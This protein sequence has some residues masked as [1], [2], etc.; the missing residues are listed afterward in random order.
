MTHDQEEAFAYADRLAIMKDGVILQCDSPEN[1]YLKPSSIDVAMF[2]GNCQFLFG[3]AHGDFAETP[4]GKVEINENLNGKVK[5]LL[6]PETLLLEEAEDGQFEVFENV[7][8]GGYREITVGNGS[9]VLKAHKASYRQYT[10]GTKVN[11]F[12]IS[13]LPAFQIK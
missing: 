6:R 1:V 10:K 12:T 3:E 9:I 5:V 8:H 7:F 11:L 4:I 13:K 2:L